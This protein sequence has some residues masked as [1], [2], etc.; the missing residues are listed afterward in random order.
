MY[1]KGSIALVTGANRGIGAEFVRELVKRDAAKIYVA[2]RDTA[3]LQ[4]LLAQSD[5]LVPLALDITK[6]DEIERA[7]DIASDVTLLINN[8]GISAYGGVLGAP[9]II[10]ARQE[11]EVNYF[12]VL[13]L[14]QAL[15]HAPAL[16]SGGA[17]VN[18]LSILS[19]VTLPVAG[20]YSASKA[21]ALSLTRTLRAELKTRGVQ[22]LGSLPVQVDTP[23]GAPC[24]SPSSRRRK[25]LRK[26]SM[27]SK[28][29]PKKSSRAFSHAMQRRP[30]GPTRRRC[31]PTCRTSSTR[32]TDRGG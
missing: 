18:V 8:A 6:P 21:A 31:K 11:M 2:A 25:S 16:Q 20:T 13:A 30:S 29:A 10:G 19:L 14:I 22:V 23:L 17:V 9:D 12:G 1:V 32:S 7:A 5:R 28:R 15:R 3:S 24:P 27:R 4:P 26:P